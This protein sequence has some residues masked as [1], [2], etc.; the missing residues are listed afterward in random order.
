MAELTHQERLQPA[1]LDRLTDDHPEQSRESRDE[2]VISLGRLRDLVMRDLGWLLNTEFLATSVDLDDYP[3]VASS[4]VNYGIPALSGNTL[5]GAKLPD[6]EHRIKVAII[7]FEPRILKHTVEVKASLSGKHMSQ[8]TLQIDIRGEL[9]AQPVPLQLFLK[10]EVDLET[11]D[12]R[13]QQTRGR[14]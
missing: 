10:T 11:G 1:L 4:V 5:T 7:N 2:R 3:H 8:S 6:L 13:V 9:W 12:V 14:K